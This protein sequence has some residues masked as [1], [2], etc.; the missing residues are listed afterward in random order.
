MEYVL[1]KSF[2]QYNCQ[3]INVRCILPCSQTSLQIG[4]IL[5]QLN[6]DNGMQ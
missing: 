4:F 3:F 5:N 1:S 6:A 2:A